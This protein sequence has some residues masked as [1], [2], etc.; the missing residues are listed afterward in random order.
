MIN[1]IINGYQIIK[2]IGS[3]CF[4]KVYEAI[5]NDKQFAIKFIDLDDIKKD[6]LVY[7]AIKNELNISQ[8]H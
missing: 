3:G 7:S 5:K 8:K 6:E 4:G 2:K 1:K